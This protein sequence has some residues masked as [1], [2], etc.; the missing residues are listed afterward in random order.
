MVWYYKGGGTPPT[1]SGVI[2]FLSTYKGTIP[3]GYEPVDITD[4]GYIK[5]GDSYFRMVGVSGAEEFEVGLW[6]SYRLKA[7]RTNL[8][9]WDDNESKWASIVPA[10]VLPAG[11]IFS[12]GGSSAPSGYLMCDGSSL[13]RTDY[14]RLFNA[15]S[16][17]FGSSGV[18]W[19]NIP[20]FE[21]RFLRGIDNGAGRDPD[22]AGRL[23]MNLGGNTGDAVGSIQDDEFETHTHIQNQHRHTCYYSSSL[24]MS[25]YFPAPFNIQNAGTYTSYETPTNQNAGGSTETRP[26][27][28]YINF[29]IKL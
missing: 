16:T 2:L 21:G 7:S 3:S 26:K 11:L 20:D 18:S 17:A 19:F 24:N 25:Q 10:E 1:T 29:I 27:N 6:N 9:I 23:A 5:K 22:A 14:P 15:I 8:E 28:A 13:K 4:G 12:Y